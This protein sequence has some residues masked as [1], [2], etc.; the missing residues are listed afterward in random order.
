MDYLNALAAIANYI[1]VPG[2]A[3]G[4]QLALAIRLDKDGEIRDTEG[5]QAG[6]A[7][8]GD[9]PAHA[10][11]DRHGR[12]HNHDNLYILDGSVHVTT[13]GFN[14]VLTIMALAW[15]NATAIVEGNS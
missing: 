1:L 3:Y 5:H 9:D 15:R 8:M 13:G 6:T 12:V 11:T 7:R 2:M 14:P 4:A 10:V